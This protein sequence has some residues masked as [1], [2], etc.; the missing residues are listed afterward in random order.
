[1]RLLIAVLLVGLVSYLFRVVPLL[2]VNRVQPSPRMESTL[3]HA[4]QA[5]LTAVL[6]GMILHPFQHA[7]AAGPAPAP[8]WTAIA[9]GVLAAARGQ[10][11]LRVAAFGL[12]GYWTVALLLIV[13][14]G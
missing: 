8:F 14:S 10:P 5:A 1:M 13:T 12:I 9:V 2:L 6:V 7:G 3:G 4:A 11:M